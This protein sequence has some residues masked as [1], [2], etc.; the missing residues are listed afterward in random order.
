MACP[1]CGPAACPPDGVP[2]VMPDEI[3]VTVKIDLICLLDEGVTRGEEFSATLT[4]TPG[5]PNLSGAPFPRTHGFH[6][7]VPSPVFKR[8]YLA[9]DCSEGRMRLR[10]LFAQAQ[11]FF[12]D[13]VLCKQADLPEGVDYGNEMADGG[14]ACPE[15]WCSSGQ[16]YVEVSSVGHT[17]TGPA[18]DAGGESS[19][20]EWITGKEWSQIVHQ[21]GTFWN[22]EDYAERPDV[23]EIKASFKI[24]GIN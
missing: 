10:F 15:L 5:G 12:Y 14:I 7:S 3:F 22:G 13:Q 2:L 16:T 21:A 11:R 1:C 18:Y 23:I 17:H 20:W 4:T 8:A 6:E 9:I 19:Q 24:D